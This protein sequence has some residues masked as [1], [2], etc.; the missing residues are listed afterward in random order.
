MSYLGR[1][2]SFPPRPGEYG[3]L[4]LVEANE[5]IRQSIQIIIGTALG[6][7]VMLPEFGCKIHE[8][9]FWPANYQTAAIMERYVTEAISMWEPRIRLQSVTA[10]PS[11]DA[12]TSDGKIIIEVL[13]MINEQPD[14]R[15]LV[16]PFYL[17]PRSGGQ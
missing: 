7:R 17:I 8:L 4:T 6:E 1:G 14:E 5:D 13:Y 15:S 2:W 10:T 3:K 11:Q 16:L 9:I 12:Q